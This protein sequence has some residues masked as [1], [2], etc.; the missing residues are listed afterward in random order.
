MVQPR[1]TG[2]CHDMTENMLTGTFSINASKQNKKIDKIKI[3][4]TC[5]LLMYEMF[6]HFLVIKILVVYLLTK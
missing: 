4:F 2:N 3:L 5:D 6:A 1:K